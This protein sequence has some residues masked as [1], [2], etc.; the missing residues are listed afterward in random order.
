MNTLIDA[1]R[2]RRSVSAHLLA[3]PG[4]RPEQI[5]TILT[6]AA[7]V[8]DHGRVVPWRFVVIQG[9]ASRRLADAV[10]AAFR[11][12]NPEAVEARVTEERAKFLHAPLIV[13]VV[14]RVR[15][16]VKIPEW[17]QELSVGAAVMNLIHAANALGFG[18]S[19]LSGWPAFDRRV[20]DGLGLSPDERLAGYVHVGTPPVQPPVDRPRPALADVVTYL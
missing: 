15:P 10:A 9:E 6:V 18:T 16:H 3:A 13:A 4:P 2:T 8:P 11:A 7:R 5:E 1:L 14:A 20:L 17:E 19:W 12:D